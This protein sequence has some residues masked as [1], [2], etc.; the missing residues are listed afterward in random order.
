VTSNADLGFAFH[1][2]GFDDNARSSGAHGLGVLRINT[3][4][5]HSPSHGAVH[6]PGI[7]IGEAKL[8]SN[9]TGNAAFA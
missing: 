7:H 3:S 5:E 4:L 1:H 6:V 2:G 8:L 9:E